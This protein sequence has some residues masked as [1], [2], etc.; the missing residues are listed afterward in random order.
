MLKKNSV[1]TDRQLL[2]KLEEELCK[3]SDPQEQNLLWQKII[4]LKGYNYNNKEDYLLKIE[5]T[6]KNIFSYH[7][8]VDVIIDYAKKII[9]HD[10]KNPL[11]A[12][13][14]YSNGSFYFLKMLIDF[15][16]EL[17]IFNG[18]KSAKTKKILKEKGLYS[19]ELAKVIKLVCS[20]PYQDLDKSLI[21]TNK[22]NI[23]N[24]IKQLILNVIQFPYSN[25]NKLIEPIPFHLES[26]ANVS[27]SAAVN[28]ALKTPFNYLLDFFIF[29]EEDFPETNAFKALINFLG[30]DLNMNFNYNTKPWYNTFP[31]HYVANSRP[32]HA[33]IFIESL[34]CSDPIK[35]YGYS[36]NARSKKF[37]TT[38]LHLAA[39]KAYRDIDAEGY[40]IKLSYLEFM[41]SILRCGADVNLKTLY[42]G[43]QTSL[44][45]ACARHDFEVMDILLKSGANANAKNDYEQTPLD[46]LALP[47]KEREKMLTEIAIIHNLNSFSKINKYGLDDCKKLLLSYLKS[48]AQNSPQKPKNKFR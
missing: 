31:H 43:Q 24:H 23:C 42:H 21:F 46:I 25:T 13:E 11:Y 28:L 48:C 27:L 22:G 10:F 33:K 18:P 29:I 30:K 36:I 40:P 7:S 16:D 37:G 1:A 32:Q 20:L 5:K 44:H 35:M 8:N 14:K 19:T 9:L 6:A 45:L 2:D 17:L 47:Y 12:T 41:K 34:F 3:L 39:A 15:E 26:V 38:I 4:T